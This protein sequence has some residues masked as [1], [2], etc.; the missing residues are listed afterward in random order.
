MGVARPSTKLSSSKPRFVSHLK[1]N[2]II[3]SVLMFIP[4]KVII[5]NE[6]SQNISCWSKV[7]QLLKFYVAPESLQMPR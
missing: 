5:N 4:P 3:S 7:Q 6:F 1:I 2:K